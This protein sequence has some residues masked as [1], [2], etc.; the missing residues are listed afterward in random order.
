VEAKRYGSRATYARSKPL[1]HGFYSKLTAVYLAI[2]APRNS[3]WLLPLNT[4]LVSSYCANVTTIGTNSSARVWKCR[5]EQFSLT[6]MAQNSD[7]SNAV[8][9]SLTGV[10]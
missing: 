4:Q 9:D 1:Q 7:L 2:H 3:V 6:M 5:R 8:S 10:S